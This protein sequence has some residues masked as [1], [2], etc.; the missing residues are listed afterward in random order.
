VC[1][2]CVRRMLGNDWGVWGDVMLDKMAY[3]THELVKSFSFLAAKQD[4]VLPQMAESVF[5]IAYN[6]EKL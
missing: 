4:P 3:A 6:G 1:G 5:E 2:V